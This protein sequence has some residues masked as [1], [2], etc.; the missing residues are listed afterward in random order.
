M[1]AVSIVASGARHFSGVAAQ[2]LL[3]A[4]IIAALALALGPVY[5]PADFIA[6][7]DTAAAA[8][9]GKSA[10]SLEANPHFVGP[11]QGFVVR[12]AGYAPGKQT[13]VKIETAESTSYVAAGVDAAGNLSVGLTLWTPGRASLTALQTGNNG[14]WAV[15]ANCWV[16][17]EA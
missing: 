4:A 1:R 12:G 3:I 14:R 2:A 15:M 13:W 10:A 8:R 17:V 9:G 7:T 11:G 5:R 6:G 16:E